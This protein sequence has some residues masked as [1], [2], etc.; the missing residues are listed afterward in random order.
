M[1]FELIP[2]KSVGDLIIGMS[3]QEIRATMG[4]KPF[5]F[6]KTK[7]SERLTDGFCDLCVQVFYDRADQA[8]FIELSRD[9]KIVAE[10]YGIPIFDTPA[11]KLLEQ[12]GDEADFK[13]DSEVDPTNV[14]FPDLSM[15]LWR[16][17]GDD[18]KDN[19]SFFFRTVG[20]GRAGYYDI[21]NK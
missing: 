2:L 11:I 12:L 6:Y 15:S 4:E 18:P 17:Y 14:I 8:E 13:T 20:L 19:S 7:Q 1:Q 21:L 10:L 16:P 5:A 3:R 9:S